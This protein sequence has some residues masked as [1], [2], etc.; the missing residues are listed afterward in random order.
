MTRRSY[1]STFH[2]RGSDDDKPTPPQLYHILVNEL[3]YIDVCLDPKKFDALKQPWPNHAYCN[4]PWS[5][6]YKF[7]D[8]AVRANMEG[9]EVLMFIPFDPS[10]DWFHKLY[11]RNPL[12]IFFLEPPEHYHYPVMLV[13]LASY[14]KPMVAFVKDLSEVK[15]LLPSLPVSFKPR[16]PT[17]S[18]NLLVA[19]G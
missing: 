6:K 5:I 8:A 1:A 15:K 13:H 2:P 17:T 11:S 12:I 9:K 4:P 18:T 3:G 7:V 14:P 10:T 19:E 16:A